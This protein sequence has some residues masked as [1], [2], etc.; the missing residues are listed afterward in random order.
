M[1][2]IPILRDPAQLQTGNQTLQTANL[3]AVTNAPIGKA[4]GDVA[5][6]AIDIQQKARRA[7]DVTNLTTASLRMNEAQMQFAE[8]QRT[9]PDE[10]KWLDEWK[11]LE[12]GLQSDIANMPLTPDARAQLTNRFSTWSTNGTINV[13]AQ[14]FKQAGRN[15]ELAVQNAI[16]AGQQTGDFSTAKQ[17]LSDLESAIPMSEEEREAMRLQVAG[18]ERKFQA[19]DFQSKVRMARDRY[20]GVGLMNA[21]MEAEKQGVLTPQEVKEFEDEAKRVEAF[22][23]VRQIADVDPI[24]AKAKIKAGEFPELTPDEKLKAETY[25]EGVQRDFQQRERADFAD[26]V[27]NGGNAQDFKFKWNLSDAQQA[28]LREA[29]KAPV[30]LTE[31]Q[32]AAMRLELESQIGKY[33]MDKDPDRLQMVRISAMLDAYKQAVPYMASDLAM[34]WG[35]KKGGEKGNIASMEIADNDDY[36]AKLYKPKMDALLDDKGAIKPGKEAEFRKLQSEATEKKKLFRA[37]IGTD[38][39]P[40]KARKTSQNILT[41][42]VADEVA[43]YFDM[44]GI[45]STPLIPSLQNQPRQELQP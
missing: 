39:T 29:A 25:A 7:N 41:M 12:T 3:P 19:E 6:V 18:A 1:A 4:L 42:P 23:T 17:A 24:I 33:D 22:G 44:F 34:S 13:Q 26:F 9:N 20:D 28:E 10:S 16:T 35:G 11:R 43:N 8:F 36:I 5:N 32:A 27:T 2:R 31:A 21:V 40:E 45:D 38:P 37:Q 30:S 14:A 15:A